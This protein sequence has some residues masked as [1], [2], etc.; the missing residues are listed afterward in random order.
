MSSPTTVV[1]GVDGSEQAF[2]AA[3]WALDRRRSAPCASRCGP[4][5]VDPA[6]PGRARTR[7]GGLSDDNLRD[8]AQSVLDDAVATRARQ[9]PRS[10][11]TGRSTQGLLGGTA[12]RRRARHA[13]GG[14]KLRAGPGDRVHPRVGHPAGRHPRPVPRRRRSVASPADEP[15]LEAG[16]VVVGID[17]SEL[18]VDATQLAFE[19]A[20]LRHAGLTLLHVWN[21]PSYDTAGVVMPNTLNPRRGAQR[22]AA[23]DG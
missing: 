7:A 22:R 5:L 10:Q 12:R 14:R 23:C 19:E 17:G 15:G 3:Q 13:C 4:Q 11:S 20:S 6:S 2:T 1:V 18:S 16:R 9:L 8:A 21:A